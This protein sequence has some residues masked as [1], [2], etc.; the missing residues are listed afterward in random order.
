MVVSEVTSFETNFFRMAGTSEAETWVSGKAECLL[1]IDKDKKSKLF[2]VTFSFNK[3]KWNNCFIKR[4]PK[5]YAY[6]YE[7]CKIKCKMINIYTSRL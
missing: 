7:I 5:N 2:G 6:A 4:D 3:C 1:A